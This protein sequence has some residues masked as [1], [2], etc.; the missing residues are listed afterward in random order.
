MGVGEAAGAAAG[1]AAIE[2]LRE[3]ERRRQS[4]VERSSGVVVKIKE[5]VKTGTAGWLLLIVSVLLY[6]S[7]AFVTKFNGIDIKFFFGLNITDL[8]MKG[9]FLSLLTIMVI[10]Q[11]LFSKP[12][13]K[14][15][16]WWAIALDAVL[17]L[18]ILL[19]G[20][21]P[22]AI[23]HLAFAAALWFIIIK[24]KKGATTEES[25]SAYKTMVLLLIL[26]FVGF[27]LLAI[28]F[29][30]LNMTFVAGILG[31]KFIFPIYALYL[32]Y[33]LGV[34]NNST[35]ASILLFLLF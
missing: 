20:Y 25:T 21:N 9:G 24:P 11:A 3:R 33:H 19:T 6:Y 13:S 35:V 4:E 27:S 14:E 22:G 1:R 17:I 18:I 8:L 2:A 15:E 23:Y 7:D 28:L 12:K 30:S 16:W 32:L 5:K 26:D 29:N 34:Y 31:N 10:F